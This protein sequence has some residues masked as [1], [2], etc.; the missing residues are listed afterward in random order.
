MFE[1]I[2]YAFE[3]IRQILEAESMYFMKGK[4][5]ILKEMLLSLYL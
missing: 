5:K 3:K 2:M 1:R 4:Y